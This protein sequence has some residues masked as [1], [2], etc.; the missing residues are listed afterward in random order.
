MVK[1]KYIILMILMVLQFSKNGYS[2]FAQD[3]SYESNMEYILTNYYILGNYEEVIRLLNRHYS[4]HQNE[5]A[6]LY[7]LVI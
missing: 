1:V 6:Y 2:I 7:G 3:L 5:L 4:N